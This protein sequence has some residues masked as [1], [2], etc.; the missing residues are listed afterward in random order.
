MSRFS[1]D[2][3]LAF[4]VATGAAEVVVVMSTKSPELA[5]SKDQIAAL[6][7]GKAV[8]FP[9]GRRA[10]P[11]DHGEGVAIRNAFYEVFTGQSAAQIKAHWAKII[12]TGCGR[13][14]KQVA[15]GEAAKRQLAQNPDALAYLDAEQVDA[16]VRVV[17]VD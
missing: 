17:S 7:L 5:L 10:V 11:I 8:L 16:S 12:F 3:G 4:S 6:F 1:F 14:P 13:P 9:D 2:G 15:D